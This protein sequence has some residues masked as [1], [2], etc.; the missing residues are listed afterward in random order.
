MTSNITGQI[1][2]VKTRLDEVKGISRAVPRRDRQRARGTIEG[3]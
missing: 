1:A 2:G 3:E